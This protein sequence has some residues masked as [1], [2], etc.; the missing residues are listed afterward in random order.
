MPDHTTALARVQNGPL[1]PP[2]PGSSG[3]YL[4]PAIDLVVRSGARHRPAWAN[5]R[6]GL[7]RERRRSG[8]MGAG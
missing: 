7:E 3:A 2:T 1:S 8:S 4:E 5:P 6:A